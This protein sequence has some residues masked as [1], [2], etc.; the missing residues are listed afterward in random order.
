LARGGRR[1]HQAFGYLRDQLVKASLMEKYSFAGR[2]GGDFA[3]ESAEGSDDGDLALGPHTTVTSDNQRADNFPIQQ[4]DGLNEYTPLSFG[5]R[6]G[7]G[8][9]WFLAT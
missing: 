8:S 2:L 4:L 5:N 1:R 9:E 3:E 6:P 7:E